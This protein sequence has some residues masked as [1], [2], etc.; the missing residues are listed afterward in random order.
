MTE[1]SATQLAEHYAGRIDDASFVR[2]LAA[3]G[4]WGLLLQ[5]LLLSL[6]LAEAAVT[7]AERDQLAS[8]IAGIEPDEPVTIDQSLTEVLDEIPVRED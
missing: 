6:R 2:N 5:E 4:E 1:M 7:S 8:L 3:G